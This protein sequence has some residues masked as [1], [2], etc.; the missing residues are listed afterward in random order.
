[1]P[2]SVWQAFLRFGAP[3]GNLTAAELQMP[4]L[5]FQIG[6]APRRIDILT[7]ID[8]VAFDEAWTSKTEWEYEGRRYPVIGRQSLIKNKRAVGRLKDLADAEWLEKHGQ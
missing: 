2:S 8:G 7:T 3:I 5:V 1:M 4:D 6:I